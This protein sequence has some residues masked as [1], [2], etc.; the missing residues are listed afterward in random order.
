MKIK[1]FSSKFIGKQLSRLKMGQAYYAIAISTINA[2]SL[3][4]L[5]FKFE[6]WVLILLFPILLFSILVIGY[7]MDIKNIRT[8]DYIKADEMIHRSLLT[9]DCKT[10]EFQLILIKVVLNALQS[11]K[12]NKDIN[13]DY[14]MEEYE[15]YK[16]RWKLII[17]KNEKVDIL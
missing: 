17:K 6:I 16:K 7:Y 12:D 13:F 10:Q 5:A 11:I 1:I 15:K 9:S 14:A 8:E 3:I 4:T 2:I